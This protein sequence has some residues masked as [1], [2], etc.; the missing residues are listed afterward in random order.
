MMQPPSRA[1]AAVLAGAALLLAGCGGDEGSPG[2]AMTGESAAAGDRPTVVV[3]TSILGDVVENLAGDELRVV[4]IMPV[5]VDPHDFQASAQEVAQI[6]E[7]DAIIVNGAGFEGG[8]LDVVESAEGDGVPVFAAIDAVETIEF[9]EH[10][11]D[12]DSRD[13]SGDANEHGHDGVDPH[14][15]TDPAR[16]ALAADGIVEFLAADVDGIDVAALEDNAAAYISELQALDTDVET[17]LAGVPAER[18]VLVTNHE[19]F[20]YF[21]DRYGFEAVGTVIP[22]GTT[23]DAASAQELAEVAE[24]IKQEDVP[25]I[26][27]DTSS[28]DELA[29]A[30]AAEVGGI[31]VVELFSESLGPDGSDGATYVDMVRT[32]AGRIADALVG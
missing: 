31:D 11:H 20:G 4:T 1:L 8:L 3:T 19:V 2:S 15:F 26:F 13:E 32:N 5:G 12:S 10:K 22:S 30:L 14:F 18:R 9:G 25:A 24:L 17:L 7:A 21:A 6:G 16:M 29:A 27:A 28:S 23:V